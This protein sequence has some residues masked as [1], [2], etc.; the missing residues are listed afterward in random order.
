MWFVAGLI[1]GCAAAQAAVLLA[2]TTGTVAVAVAAVTLLA[3][4]TNVRLFAQATGTTGR[5]RLAWLIAGVASSCWTLACL[6][7]LLDVLTGNDGP[8]PR[9]GD[10]ASLLAVCLAPGVL[11]SAPAAPQPVEQRVRLAIDGTMVS[12]ALFVLAWP[13]LLRDTMHEIGNLGGIVAIGVPSVHIAC[14]AIAI[15]LLSRSR[16]GGTT[17]VTVLTG[18]FAVFAVATLG[19]L[20]LGRR[21]GS[22]Y[23]HAMPAGFGTASGLLY[24][25]GRFRMPAGGEEP[26]VPLG[27][28]A[29]LPYLPVAGAFVVAGA[30]YRSGAVDGVMVSAL[31]LVAGLVLVRQHLVL[32]T[33]SQLL[34]EV[35]RARA[36]LA[37]QATHDHL[38]GL[39]NRAL[40]YAS[41]PDLRGGLV[42]LDL[43][44]FKQVNDTLGHPAGDRVLIEAAGALRSAVR[45]GDLPVRLGGDEFAVLLTDVHDEREAVAVADRVIAA[46]VARVS[47]SGCPVPVGAS[48]GV[49]VG[50][51]G[52]EMFRLADAALYRSKAAGKGRVELHVP[53]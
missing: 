23:V 13:L 43:D 32:R 33:N 50:V 51:G 3:L 29:A 2:P 34:A 19:Y 36:E 48:A 30:A 6:L 4:A 46:I 41:L 35:Q 42:L 45:A 22:W 21:G 53:A 18:G 49:V 47:A 20:F 31:L 40:L 28:R 38:T 52:E 26:A 9:A 14:I 7:Y 37:H 44:G 15:V 8:P 11:L 12:A 27:W 16:L 39:P 17:A 1:A 25:A 5:G 10:W 24:F